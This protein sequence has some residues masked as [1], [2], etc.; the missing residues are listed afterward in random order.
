MYVAT[1]PSTAITTNASAASPATCN[2]PPPSSIGRTRW[3]SQGDILWLPTT[4]S[5]MIFSGHGPARLIAVSTSMASRMMASWPRY[6]RINS[7]MRR[8]MPSSFYAAAII[9]CA[10]PLPKLS[11][12]RRILLE[13][14]RYGRVDLVQQFVLVMGGKIVLRHAP[15]HQLF[16][17]W[18]KEI[19]HQLPL[20][21]GHNRVA[22]GSHKGRPIQTGIEGWNAAGPHIQWI[23]RVGSG[24]LVDR[25]VNLDYQVWVAG[26]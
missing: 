19:D 8:I 20:V 26:D 7:R 12:G 21:D 16:R 6:G 15:P 1:A 2:L 4:L 11:L 9:C 13:H 22:P 14:L 17:G 3:S 23:I 24:F 25:A 18:I 10:T 5:M